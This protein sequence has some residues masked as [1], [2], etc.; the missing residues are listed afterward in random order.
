M[1]KDFFISYHE[2]DR[3]WAEWICWQL[4]AAGYI[5]FLKAWDVHAGHN[6][7][8]ETHEAS[9][10][11]GRFIAVLSPSYL[12]ST[13]QAQWTVALAEDP[14]GKQRKLLPIRV[15]ECEPVGLFKPIEMID[16]M[17]LD[18]VAARVRLLAG[19]QNKRAKPSV[20]PIYPG[21]ASP[22]LPS[23][24]DFPGRSNILIAS[25]GE[26]PAVISAMYDLLTEQEKLSI[27]RL[28]VLCPDGDDV[29]R[30]Y[31]LVQ[32]TLPELASEGRLMCKELRLKDACSWKD[33]CEFLKE[34]Y[35]LLRL[36]Q[37]KGDTVYLSLA[38]GRKSMSALMAWMVPFFPCVERLYHVI[39]KDEQT[40][41]GSH[42]FLPVDDIDSLPND[43]FDYVM[44]PPAGKLRLVKIPFEQGWQLN[45]ARRAELFSATT[46]DLA[47]KEY[48]DEQALLMVQAMVQ[49]A[50]PLQ[51]YVT[52]KVVRQFYALRQWDTAAARAV[53]N[54]LISMGEAAVLLR[55]L[56]D[57]AEQETLLFQQRNSA[58]A[59]KLLRFFN[60]IDASVRPVFYT[61]PGDIADYPDHPLIKAVVCALELVTMGG[62]YRPLREVANEVDFSLKG[63]L[64]LEHLLVSPASAE[65]VLIVPLGKYPMV[66]TQLYTLLR[67]R[68]DRTIREVVLIYPGLAL[69]IDRGA[70]IV[71]EALWDEDQIP[72][73]LVWV[74]GEQKGQFDDIDSAEACN[75][76]QQALEEVIDDV[77][78]RYPLCKIDLALSGGR[79]GMTA[80]TIFAAQRK[81]ISV[82]YHTIVNDDDLSEKIEE[83]TTVAALQKTNLGKQRQRERLFL[84][85][86]CPPDESYPYSSFA[87]F[88][89][90]VFAAT[91]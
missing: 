55:E 10:H 68:E 45:Q 26:S 20:A 66:A 56:C 32:R 78:D 80:M 73:K 17:G 62:R 12:A 44:H 58:K 11:V 13:D 40:A 47:K 21:I 60:G 49:P 6:L 64:D 79:K 23:A 46:D 87:L 42:F 19:I 65:S 36:H 37:E 88:R 8:W 75:H 38:G 86:Y 25:L 82:V 39:D 35:M 3:A 85:E 15:R 90:P 4:E 61:D 59:K 67:Q 41:S 77:R 33:T 84:R 2:Q 81:G 69:T 27:D 54:G 51:V 9:Q 89:V 14:V 18:E 71:K 72:C 22:V 53:K 76:F 31:K 1:Q 43:K 74:K 34:L 28:V 24:P 50:E 30:A 48:E 70:K 5:C 52:E 29:K 16:I 83:E 7:V 63:T 57:D 91:D